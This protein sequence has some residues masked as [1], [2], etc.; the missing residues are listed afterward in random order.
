MDREVTDDSGI[1][2]RI[3]QSS[4]RSEPRQK[5]AVPVT[6]SA[7]VGVF[8]GGVSGA[9][10]W[11]VMTQR[12]TDF[13]RRLEQQFADTRQIESVVSSQETKIEVDRAQYTEILR[14]L[15]DLNEKIERGK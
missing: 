11:G 4:D 14:R 15:N 8:I 5:V 12:M 9:I 3:R 13:E 2:Q 1:Y 7:V 10:T 6:W